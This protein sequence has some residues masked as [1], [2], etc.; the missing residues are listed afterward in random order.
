MNNKCPVFYYQAHYK[1]CILPF[2]SKSFACIRDNNVTLDDIHFN[3]ESM[4]LTVLRA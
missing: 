2:I 1:E 3:F 4:L